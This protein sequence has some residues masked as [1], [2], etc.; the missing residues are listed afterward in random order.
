VLRTLVDLSQ[1]T[2]AT[3]GFEEEPS[4]CWRTSADAG[5]PRPFLPWIDGE[6]IRSGI[7][8]DERLHRGAP[9]NER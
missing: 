3:M 5:G 8:M 1:W 2:G 4:D 7:R 9:L 6:S